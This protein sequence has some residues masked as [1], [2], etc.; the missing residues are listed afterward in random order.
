M[1]ESGRGEEKSFFQFGVM[2]GRGQSSVRVFSLEL[3]K[4]EVCAWLENLAWAGKQKNLQEWLE[5]L[6]PYAEKKEFIID[7]DVTPQVY[8]QK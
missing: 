4:E 7:F 8:H 5:E 6:E 2:A 1:I 3:K